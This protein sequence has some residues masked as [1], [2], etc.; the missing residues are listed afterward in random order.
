[1]PILDKW[2]LDFVSHSQD[3]TWRLGVRL[4]QLLGVDD[5][6]CLAGEI[7]VGKTVLAQGIGHGWGTQIPVT[8]AMHAIVK[9]YPH[10]YDARTLFHIDCYRLSGIEEVI[11]L[12]LGELFDE[13]GTIMIEWPEKMAV[14]LPHD[15]LW[16]Q[17][18]HVDKNR[19]NLRFTASGS[20]SMELVHDFRHSAFGI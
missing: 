15:R 11:D 1:M 17:M 10:L 5:V 4:G 12:G 2:T 14:L 7:G 8:S 3:Q 9:E 6:V 16:V 13:N 19:R 18:E 20:R